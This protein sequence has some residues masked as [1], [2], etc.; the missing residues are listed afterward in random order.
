MKLSHI[1]LYVYSILVIN[2][3]TKHTRNISTELMI[4][5]KKNLNNEVTHKNQALI[6]FTFY[7][8]LDATYNYSQVSRQIYF[9]VSAPFIFP[10]RVSIL[11]LFPR[12]YCDWIPVDSFHTFNFLPSLAGRKNQPQMY[13][14]ILLFIYANCSLS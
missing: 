14:T 7:H 12:C 2:H 8:P 1:F 10:S 6:Y 13:S 3:K 9:Q 11:P 4:K 5:K